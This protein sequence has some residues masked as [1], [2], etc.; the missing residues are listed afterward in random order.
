MKKYHISLQL[1]FTIILAIVILPALTIIFYMANIQYEKQTL[2]QVK[3]QAR[4]LAAQIIMTRKWISDCGGV[5]VLGKSVGAKNTIYFFN[6]RMKTDRG[7]Y[8]RFTPSMVTKKLSTYSEQENLFRFRLA[9]LNPLNPE[10]KPDNFEMAALTIFKEKDLSEVSTVETYN[11][12]KFMRFMV[13]LH[14]DKSCLKC[15]KM[16]TAQGK[17]T[18]IGGLSVFLPLS[19]VQSSLAMDHLKLATPG[20]ALI[21]ITII[22]LLALLRYFVMNPLKKM[23]LATHEIK[24]GNLNV[25]IDINTGDE[26]D[27]LGLAFNSMALKLSNSRDSLEEKIKQATY[28]LSIA[29]TELKTLDKLKSDF[30]ANMSHELRSPLTVIRGGVDY[31][32]RTVHSKESTDY[33]K[34]VDKNVTRLIHLVSEIFDFTKI[35][36]GKASWSFNKENISE[37]VRET[38]EILTPIANEK[39]ILLT[40]SGEQEDSYV[41]IDFERIEQVMVNLIDNAIK[42]SNTETTIAIKIQEKDHMVTISVTDQGIGIEEKNIKVIFDKFFTLPSSISREASKGTGLGLAICKM[43]IKAHGGNIWAESSVGKGSVFFV[44]LPEPPKKQNDHFLKT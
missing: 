35:E 33:L 7:Q 36:A 44:S 6:D 17:K 43:I 24:T 37:L 42:F 9:S 20:L 13:P 41:C 4:V 25:R 23:E 30:I 27:Q 32:T 12:K 5:M 40:Y 8:Q 3:N 1:K 15:H 29:N 21:C 11:S 2:E 34:I 38:I 31:L 22:T 10:N 28:D 16:K 26:F 18:V 39:D 14:V 19:K